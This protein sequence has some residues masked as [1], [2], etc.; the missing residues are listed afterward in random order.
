M[1]FQEIFGAPS[2]QRNKKANWALHTQTQDRDS[3]CRLVLVRSQRCTHALEKRRRRRQL[4]RGLRR[5]GAQRAPLARGNAGHDHVRQEVQAG[6]RVE[7]QIAGAVLQKGRGRRPTG[8]TKSKR[9]R[10]HTME[11]K[12]GGRQV[13]KPL[14]LHH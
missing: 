7:R 2:H 14:R 8:F 11:K 4:Q 13:E 12:G 9:K 6:G 5:I 10:Q 1:I 3:Y